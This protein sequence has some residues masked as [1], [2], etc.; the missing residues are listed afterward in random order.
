MGITLNLSSDKL[1]DEDLQALTRELCQQIN[2]NTEVQAELSTQEEPDA[3]GSKV[4]I[5]LLVLKLA[6]D[7]DHL[8]LASFIII[9]E[10]YERRGI[11]ISLKKENGEFYTL[12]ELKEIVKKGEWQ[13]L[14][15]F[16]ITT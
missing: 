4:V 12:S 11:R 10:E 2:N 14:I 13:K 6:I 16:S 15:Q 7:M 9:L 5:G 8:A 3:K 1:D